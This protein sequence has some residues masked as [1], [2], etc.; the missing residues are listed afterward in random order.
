MWIRTE[1]QSVGQ[2]QQIHTVRRER[3]GGKVG[4]EV[5]HGPMFF[6]LI[7]CL[8][9]GEPAMGYAVGTQSLKFGD[10][11]LQSVVAEK[12]GYSFIQLGLFPFQQVRSRRGLEPFLQTYNLVA[13]DVNTTARID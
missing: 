8:L 9:H 4:I 13:H 7:P 1:L 6:R 3:Q 12:I 5:D 11:E 2:Y 10:P